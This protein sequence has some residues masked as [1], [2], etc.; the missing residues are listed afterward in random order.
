MLGEILHDVMKKLY[1]DFTGKFL[2]VET[3]DML[4][5]D[6]QLLERTIIDTVSAKF[7]DE[8]ERIIEGNEFI[9]RDVLFA[10]VIRILRN[11]KSFAPFRIL[12]L[13]SVFSFPVYISSGNEGYEVLTGEKWTGLI[14]QEG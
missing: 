8:S 6:K 3:I 1:S 13:E 11:D 14:R 7:S 4:I 2:S 9:I 5:G 12:H 10:Y